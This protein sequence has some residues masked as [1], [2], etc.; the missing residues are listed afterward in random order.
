MLLV[1]EN[2]SGLGTD[3]RGNRYHDDGVA[4]SKKN[5]LKIAYNKSRLTDLQRKRKEAWGMWTDPESS[6]I[7]E[8]ESKIFLKRVYPWSIPGN[9]DGSHQHVLETAPR[10]LASYVPYSFAE[11]N[12]HNERSRLGERQ[13][14]VV[15]NVS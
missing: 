11:T 1:V 15:H 2:V 10:D 3:S 5:M 12:P 14:T 9:V 13:M 6:E 7:Q 4:N 8:L